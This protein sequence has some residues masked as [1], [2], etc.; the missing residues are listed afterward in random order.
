MA[1]KTK[2]EMFG[3]DAGF[4]AQVPFSTVNAPGTG[5]GNRGI[6]FGE[7]L[8]A[9]IANRTHYALALNDEDLDS[10][11]ASVETG[12]LDSAYRGG[13]TAT[14]GI[15]RVID[16]DGAAVELRT[17]LATMYADDPANAAMRVS[18][19]NDTLNATM[20]YDFLGGMIDSEDFSTGSGNF[21]YIDRRL[22]GVRSG[23]F[24]TRISGTE[25]ATVNPGGG[26]PTVIQLSTAGRTFW[27]SYA[28]P[29]PPAGTYTDI[30]LGFDL[31]E[32][33]DGT[34]PG[35]YITA[36]L[37]TNDTEISV[38]DLNVN[39]PSFTADEVVNIRVWRVQFGSIGHHPSRVGSLDGNLISAKGQSAAALKL[40]AGGADSLAGQKQISYLYAGQDGQVAEHLWVDEFGR[41]VS[42]L[43]GGD[44]PYRLGGSDSNPAYLDGGAFTTRTERTRASVG[45]SEFAHIVLASNTNALRRMDYTSL[46]LL[47]DATTAFDNSMPFDFTANSPTTG[48]L[49]MTASSMAGSW[50]D[51]L[52]SRFTLVEI[53]SPSAQAGFYW[54]FSTGT[55]PD[56]INVNTIDD[57]IPTDFP[58]S[59]S[60]TLRV[61]HLSMLGRRADS[62]GVEEMTASLHPTLTPYN[63]LSGGPEDDSCT[64]VL[65]SLPAGVGSDQRHLIR[66]FSQSVATGAN[67]W[68][69]YSVDAGGTVRTRGG[70]RGM[71]DIFTTG[72]ID[73]DGSFTAGAFGEFN[74][75]VQ[76]N[77]GVGEFSYNSLR[78]REIQIP[79]KAF[80]TGTKHTLETFPG[81]EGTPGTTAI[82]S[83]DDNVIAF[84]DLKPYLVSGCTI[85]RLRVVWDPGAGSRSGTAKLLLSL[86]RETPDY[87][88]PA[89]P[90]VSLISQCA[91]DG[92]T[93][94]QAD[95]STFTESGV[96]LETTTY[97]LELQAGDDGGTHS[98]DIVYSVEIQIQ[99][100][101]P[102]NG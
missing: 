41:V 21:G 62:I 16:V 66:G 97:F 83:L 13:A 93:G 53:I 30:R 99:D 70:F 59:G 52:V 37:G 84:L 23:S 31:I 73:C 49:D 79:V 58:T 100:P 22:Y 40:F 17:V 91:D 25:A 51:Y 29:T 42:E 76:I 2:E 72:S 44:L 35:L 57:G 68:E 9:A 78:Q 98:P 64:L 8:T 36:A 81:W 56:A 46:Y 32:I 102:R 50:Q 45:G 69:A 54:V 28:G 86:Y 77:D 85:S 96:D 75:Y 14:P 1:I 89:A 10:R 38:V 20:G 26:N 82:Q 27:T 34:D 88:T 90:A 19:V 92:T 5:S 15:G 48:E 61:H 71:N 60:G 7:Q 101:G 6:D 24:A 47:E 43:V 4:G 67:P 94:I 3:D 12:G 74:G 95:T 11:I 63:V 55:G 80:S 87:L 65:V 18:T 33:L 39:S